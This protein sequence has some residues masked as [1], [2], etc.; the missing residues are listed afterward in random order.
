M[1]KKKHEIW[2]ESF[3]SSHLVIFAQDEKGNKYEVKFKEDNP[4]FLLGVA[5][6]LSEQGIAKMSRVYCAVQEVKCS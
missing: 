2:A 3:S 5:R 6:M 1:N 4:L